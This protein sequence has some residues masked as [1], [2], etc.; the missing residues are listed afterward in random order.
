MMRET[1][2]H[3]GYSQG[4]MYLIGV[5]EM[6]GGVGLLI[7]ALVVP[8]AIGLAGIM[9]GAI[10]SHLLYDPIYLAIPALILLA[11][12]IGIAW[13]YPKAA[14][15]RRFRVS[16]RPYDGT[17]GTRPETAPPHPERTAEPVRHSEPELRS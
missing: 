16:P 5:L 4:F 6:S 14:Y 17:V 2:A 12:L 10:I 7:P 1:F 3:F 9:V 8:A 15:V 13:T 11:L